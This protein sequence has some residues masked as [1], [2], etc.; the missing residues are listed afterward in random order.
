VIAPVDSSLRAA[1]GRKGDDEAVNDASLAWVARVV[2][3][4]WTLRVSGMGDLEMAGQERLARLLA[5]QEGRGW[6]PCDVV[7]VAH[8]GSVHQLPRLYRALAPR[9]ALIGVGRDNDYGHPAERALAMLVD[10]GAVVHRTDRSGTAVIYP[11]PHGGLAVAAG[12]A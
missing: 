11:V 8:H 5:G 10:C 4:G 12:P 7:V 9:V 3:S 2:A 1:A 6:F